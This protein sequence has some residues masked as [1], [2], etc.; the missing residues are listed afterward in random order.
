LLSLGSFGDI[1]KQEPLMCEEPATAAAPSDAL[2]WCVAEI[3][4]ISIQV[5]LS[6]DYYFEIQLSLIKRFAL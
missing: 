6:R 5:F 2:A 3:D 1:F 4:G